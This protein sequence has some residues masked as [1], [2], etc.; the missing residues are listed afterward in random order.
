MKKILPVLFIITLS[1]FNTSIAQP[2]NRYA[3]F[4]GI[5]DG[6]T[7]NLVIPAG[8][9][10][11]EC[12]YRYCKDEVFNNRVLFST[13]NLSFAMQKDTDYYYNSMQDFWFLQTESNF[14]QI[15]LEGQRPASNEW[16]HFA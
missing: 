1:E 7:S 8:S 12:Y 14:G 13:D 15:T 3:R 4:D 9:F 6:F 16:T 11:I 5:D 10:T 2:F